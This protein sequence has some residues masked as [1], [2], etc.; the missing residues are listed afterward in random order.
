MTVTTLAR[1]DLILLVPCWPSS[2]AHRSQNDDGRCPIILQRCVEEQQAFQLGVGYQA[3][4]TITNGLK[5]SLATGNWGD[6][7]K[8]MSSKAGV[9][10]VLNRY[11]FASTLSHLATNQHAYWTRWQDCKA[12]PASQYSLGL[13]LPGRDTRRSGLWFGQEPVSDVL[14]QLWV[15]PSEPIVEFMISEVWKC[16][17]STSL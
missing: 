9:S 10:Q 4:N 15:R 6:Q 13:G 7:K 8:A 17:R 3:S 11:T 12:S 1:S 16:S 5:Y 14:C 2:S